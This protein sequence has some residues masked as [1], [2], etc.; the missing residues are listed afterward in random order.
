[1]QAIYTVVLL[2]LIYRIDCLVQDNS[3]SS[4]LAMEILQPCTTPSI[5]SIL[6]TIM[7]CVMQSF[8]SALSYQ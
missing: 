2:I 1:M 4:P 3:I 7:H 6:V 5:L 8:Y